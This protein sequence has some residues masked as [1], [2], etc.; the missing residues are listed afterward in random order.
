M[1]QHESSQYDGALCLALLEVF[2]K[3]NY[4]SKHMY[5]IIHVPVCYH[6]TA[7]RSH[8][9]GAALQLRSSSFV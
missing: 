6:K 7:H 2:T 8:S 5:C 4:F 1:E 3:G 9:E